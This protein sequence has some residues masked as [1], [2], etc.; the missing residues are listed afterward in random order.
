MVYVED[1]VV[2]L[3]VGVYKQ[4]TNFPI[5][6]PTNQPITKPLGLWSFA[7]AVSKLT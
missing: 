1:F 3:S 7:N 5:N 6:Q 2:N 4:T